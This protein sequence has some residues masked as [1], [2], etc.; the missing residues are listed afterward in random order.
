MEISARMT[1]RKRLLRAIRREP[2]DR[3]PVTLYEFHDL[4]GS[5]SDADPSYK[6]LVELQ[7]TYGETVILVSAGEGLLGG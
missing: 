5:K 6:P 3:I 1:S 4:G 2:V 7:R